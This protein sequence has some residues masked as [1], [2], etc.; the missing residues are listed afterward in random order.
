[1]FQIKVDSKSLDSSAD[2]LLKFSRQLAQI[3]SGVQLISKSLYIDSSAASIYR[4]TLRG[5]AAESIDNASHNMKV[6]GNALHTISAEYEAAEVGVANSDPLL[7]T[8]KYVA[9]SREVVQTAESVF[10]SLVSVIF[11]PVFFE[12]LFNSIFSLMDSSSGISAD[13]DNTASD[14]LKIKFGKLTVNPG[15]NKVIEDFLKDK[16]LLKKPDKIKDGDT[17]WMGQKSL[18]SL[19]NIK[20]TWE[21]ST[22]SGKNTSD[23][24]YGSHTEEYKINS[25]SARSVFDAGIYTYDDDGKKRVDPRMLFELGA[26]YVAASGTLSGQLGLGDNHD[27]LGIYGELKGEAGK[28]DAKV[29]SSVGII[30]GKFN[31]YAGFSAEAILAEITGKAGISIFGADIGVEASG[32]VGVGMK[33][34][35]GYKDGVV[36]AEFGGS[37]GLGG[38]I[39]IEMDVSGVVENIDETVEAVQDAAEFVYDKAVDGIN[40]FSNAIDGVFSYFGH[41]SGGGKAGGR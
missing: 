11:I 3:S 41:G 35:I 39:K 23:G 27:M 1:M 36:S 30:D 8:G 31:A 21:K 37:L 19:L 2:N 33:G 9:L 20:R 28:V 4:K 26:E 34:N 24:E 7:R 40:N 25:R 18:L 38:D 17:D 12:S 6:L 29:S 22:F 13:N 16:G 14:E 10:S 15:I 32:N 5:A